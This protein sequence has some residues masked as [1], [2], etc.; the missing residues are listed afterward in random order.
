MGSVGKSKKEQDQTEKDEKSMYKVEYE[1]SGEDKC[2]RRHSIQGKL[3]EKT[4]RENRGAILKRL[5]QSSKKGKHLPN[6]RS[7]SLSSEGPECL[8]RDKDKEGESSSENRFGDDT[9]KPVP[10]EITME[11]WQAAQDQIGTLTDTLDNVMQKMKTMQ[12]VFKVMEAKIAFMEERLSPEDKLAL[13]DKLS[14]ERKTANIVGQVPQF[15][16]TVVGTEGMLEILVDGENQGIKPLVLPLA[17]DRER[18]R[19]EIRFT[20]VTWPS[21]EEGVTRRGDEVDQDL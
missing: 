7:L 5:Q 14:L 3:R 17:E 15:G 13:E 16:C 6:R 9:T 10:A 8:P 2:I 11:D 19:S 4:D 21:E 12:D 20:R 1:S 18:N